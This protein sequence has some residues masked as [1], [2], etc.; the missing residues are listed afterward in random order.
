[1]ATTGPAEYLR[2]LTHHLMQ[3]RTSPRFWLMLPF[4]LLLTACPLAVPQ[5]IDKGSYAAPAWLSGR[6]E[7]PPVVGDQ[8][9]RFL[10][11][12]VKDSIG[13]VRIYVMD[14]Q[15]KPDRKHPGRM[16]LSA[17]KDKVFAF[18]QPG[19]E[20]DSTPM[21]G[22]AVYRFDATGP[23]NFRL[24]GLAENGPPHAADSLRTWLLQNKDNE[25][26]ID[27]SEF[28]DMHKL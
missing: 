22:Y 24:A 20:N 15:G 5:P 7:E 1:M 3:R 17:V 16:V 28:L 9:E 8:P 21:E 13:L 11:E 18:I 2:A 6:W 26:I 27:T 23:K 25:A 14:E 10:L 4:L 19:A 12:A